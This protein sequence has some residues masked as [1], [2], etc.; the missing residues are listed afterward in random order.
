VKKVIGLDQNKAFTKK[1]QPKFVG[2]EE[3]RKKITPNKALG[4]CGTLAFETDGSIFSAKSINKRNSSETKIMTN[5]FA[6]R[7]VMS[8]KKRSCDKFLCE[9]E[10]H[11]QGSAYL[12][13]LNAC[14][15]ND[16]NADYVRKF[17]SFIFKF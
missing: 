17:I 13:C 16:S 3:L 15:D 12:T 7:I 2:D 10:G 8:S 5:M 11:N 4:Q 1:D 9:C 6:K 14:E